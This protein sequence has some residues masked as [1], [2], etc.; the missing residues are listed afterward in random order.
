MAEEL[1]HMATAETAIGRVT[2]DM[3]RD[4]VAVRIWL[5]LV[6]LLIVAL[7]IV[8][9]AT[10]LTH[11]GLSITE[12]Q[13]VHGVVPPLND[14]EWQD[15][16]AKYQQIPEYKLLNQGMALADF[17]G[18]FWWE[19]THR[20]IARLI[21]FAVLVPFVFFWVTGRIERAL[22]PRL[23]AILVL[24]AMQGAIGWWMVA[25]GLSVRTDVSQYRLA[26]HLTFACVI[27]AYVLWVAR[28][29]RRTDG[30]APSGLRWITGVIVALVF[31][32]IFLGG[33]V[34]GLDAGL[35]FNTWPLMNGSLVPGGLF[36]EAPVWRNFFENGLTA[37]FDH[38]LV[39]Y[40]I[41]ALAL[42]QF[43]LARGT[44]HARRALTLTL[45][46]AAQALIGVATLLLMVPLPLALVHQFGA[47]AVLSHAVL[48]LRAMTAARSR[49]LAQAH[50]P[51]A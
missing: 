16:F 43:L 47:V 29:L 10:R 7:V 9:G 20:L 12:W 17:K 27:L 40:A 25:S 1:K 37:Q 50:L 18:I 4:R 13:P 39:A 45:L 42:L 5:Y 34:A 23:A 21:G 38:R 14:A 8:G 41:L 19:W 48:N 11:S 46:V 2:R 36:T 26:I 24:G 35:A 30:E 3:K 44:R 15:E 31:L 6:A 22:V 51:L 28:G 49:P 33:I 32:Q